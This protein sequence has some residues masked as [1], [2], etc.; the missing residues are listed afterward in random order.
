VKKGRVFQ[1]QSKQIYI[2]IIISSLLL[3]S[4]TYLIANQ[5]VYIPFIQKQEAQNTP[6]Q[7]PTPT[8]TPNPT[9]T[10]LPGEDIIWLIVR[11]ENPDKEWALC[12][13]IKKYND[14]G[15]P[16][17]EIYP[18]DSSPVSERIKIP[19]GERVRAYNGVIKADGG[20]KFY[21]LVD[22]HGIE[23]EEL[24]LRQVDVMKAEDLQSNN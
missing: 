21:K 19:V 8:S 11:P 7:T 12:Y 18:S 10:P 23:G 14:S 1:F 5:R 20:V 2:L 22:Y 4:A 16:V 9:N 15:R 6:T 13:F 3:I 24:Y 17:M